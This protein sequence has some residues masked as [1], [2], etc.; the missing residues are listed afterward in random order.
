MLKKTK[1]VASIPW[2]DVGITGE[3]DIKLDVI[4]SEA[5]R[6]FLEANLINVELI[7]IILPDNETET[8]DLY[9]IIN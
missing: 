2:E 7:Y 4:D 1:Y 3:T 8:L 6:L 5:Y 9:Q